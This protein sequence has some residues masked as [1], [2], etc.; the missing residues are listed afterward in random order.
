MER[1]NNTISQVIGGVPHFRQTFTSFKKQVGPSGSRHQVVCDF[2]IYNRCTR[3]KI[4]LRRGRPQFNN[5]TCCLFG[6]FKIPS[7]VNARK[8]CAEFAPHSPFVELAIMLIRPVGMQPP[9]L[10]NN[11]R[12]VSSSSK[13]CFM[14]SSIVEVGMGCLHESS[15]H[16]E[17]LIRVLQISV[18]AFFFSRVMFL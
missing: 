12:T 2:L 17:L 13:F 8:F 3:L 11:F 16:H 14:C 1:N 15:D 18:R 4:L 10:L 7:Y 9:A 6:G 5:V